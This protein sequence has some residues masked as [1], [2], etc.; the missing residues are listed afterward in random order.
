[1]ATWSQISEA[2]V[3]ESKT[4]VCKACF[5]VLRMANLTNHFNDSRGR[6]A[7]HC[8]LRIAYEDAGRGSEGRGLLIEMA[9]QVHT[10]LHESVQRLPS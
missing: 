5:A 7:R 9:P 10:V 3:T 6:D 2:F 4:T 8:P 1:M